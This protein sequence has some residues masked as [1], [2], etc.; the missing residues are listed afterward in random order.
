[1][2]SQTTFDLFE[3]R[4]EGVWLC[5]YVGISRVQ[6]GSPLSVF[7]AINGLKPTS[8]HSWQ[9]YHG[10][11]YLGTD[12]GLYRLGPA[13]PALG[14]AARFE[15]VPG[16]DA[17][18][19]SLCAT[20]HGLLISGLGTI[21]QFDDKDG[22]A[23]I[24]K[25]PY[26]GSIM[27]RGR[28]RS[29]RVFL[30]TRTALSS[31]RFDEKSNR[32][33]DEGPV[34]GVAAEVH[35]CAETQAGDLWLGSNDHGVWRVHFA[36][37]DAAGQRGP[38]TVTS[39]IARPGPLS[40]VVGV[41]V[42]LS[43]DGEVIAFTGQG[44][45]RFDARTQNF[46]RPS[47]YGRAFADGSFSV[48]LYTPGKPSGAW[49]LGRSTRSLWPDQQGGWEVDSDRGGDA[50]GECGQDGGCPPA[51]GVGWQRAARC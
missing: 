45:Y 44:L 37:D 31:L 43:P 19:W 13:D 21:Y 20:E 14:L 3:D 29:G 4:E 40:G 16:L 2:Q 22:A 48:Q 18:C 38:A 34:A 11:L 36:P 33:L 17:D 46:R 26:S 8:I 1:M 6:T 41:G 50:E 42:S 25:F 49:L 32:W 5:L 39:F 27:W 15:R 47:E 9:R 10:E 23:A 28:S 51:A 7:D 24:A 35:S 30:G 12:S